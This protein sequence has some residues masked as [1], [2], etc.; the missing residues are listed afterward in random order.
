MLPSGLNCPTPEVTQNYVLITISKIKKKP[1]KLLTLVLFKV[2]ILKNCIFSFLEFGN[3]LLLVASRGQIIADNITTLAQNIYSIIRN[4]R[5][6]VAIDFDSVTNRI[7]WSD[8]VQDKIWSAF[9]N[10][11]DRQIVSDFYCFLFSWAVGDSCSILYRDF[12][13]FITVKTFSNCQSETPTIMYGNY[14]MIDNCRFLI[15]ASL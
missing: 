12:S 11:T 13:C 15:V 7:Y 4:G 8:I 6:I 1:K 10:G 3:L 2:N 5:S 9:V 14:P